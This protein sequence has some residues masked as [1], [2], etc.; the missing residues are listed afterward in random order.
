V[1]KSIDAFK[2]TIIKARKFEQLKFGPLE[3]KQRKNTYCEKKTV[4]N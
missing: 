1:G 2:V 3:V 4:T